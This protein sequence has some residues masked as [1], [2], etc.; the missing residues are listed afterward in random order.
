MVFSNHIVIQ[1]GVIANNGTDTG[2]IQFPISWQS[3]NYSTT[4]SDW[5][6]LHTPHY[7]GV[8]VTNR[9]LTTQ[10]IPMDAVR[11]FTYISVGY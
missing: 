4:V 7:L 10:N 6:Y 5:N 2:I 1:Y 9:T 8:E 11:G 3:L